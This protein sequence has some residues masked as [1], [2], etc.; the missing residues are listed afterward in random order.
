MVLIKTTL[1]SSYLSC[2]KLPLCVC[3][4]LGGLEPWIYHIINIIIWICYASKK[5]K[6]ILPNIGITKIDYNKSK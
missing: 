6:K 4:K 2:F 5:A 1:V 3:S